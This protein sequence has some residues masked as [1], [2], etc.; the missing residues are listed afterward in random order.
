MNDDSW[1]FNVGRIFSPDQIPS[2]LLY[3]AAAR[4]EPDYITSWR[5]FITTTHEGNSCTE[6]PCY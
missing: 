5:A 3:T 1:E 6:F 2:L 4:C